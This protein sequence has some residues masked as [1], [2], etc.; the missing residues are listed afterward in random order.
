MNYKN[1][2]LEFY[3]G[4]M[5]FNYKFS[6]SLDQSFALIKKHIVEDYYE[7]FKES[8]KIEC[9]QDR[10]ES[11]IKEKIDKDLIKLKQAYNYLFNKGYYPKKVE[12]ISYNL[13]GISGIYEIVNIKNNKRYIGKSENISLRWSSHK[14][15]LNGNKHHCKSLQEEYNIYGKESFR[16]NVI[17]IEKDSE[18]LHYKER[19]WWEFA[20]GEKYNGSQNM[21]PDSEFKIIFLEKKVRELEK[22]L[23]E[24]MK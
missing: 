16:F 1:E 15:M 7:L 18:T 6:D 20:I 17:E 22:L 13:Y 8:L 3:I 10:I 2:T 14:T 4:Q 9:I 19:Y 11:T 23:S 5:E 12:R 24:V 21:M